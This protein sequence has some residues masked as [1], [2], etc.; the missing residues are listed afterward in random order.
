MFL[1]GRVEALSL[2]VV[3]P[4]VW[5]QNS[6]AISLVANAEG[7]SPIIAPNTWVEVKG[8]SLSQDGDIRT[9]QASDFVNGEMPTA[10]DGVSVTVGGKNAYIYYISPTQIN[11]LTPPDTLPASVAVQVSVCVLLGS[12]ASLT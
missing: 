11:I 2:L 3:L 5:A 9:W 12:A 4:A 6:P 1:F 10:L 8:A 7:E